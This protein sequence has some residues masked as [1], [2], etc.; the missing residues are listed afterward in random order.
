MTDRATPNHLLRQSREKVPSVQIA[1][2]CAS[3][4]EI[5]ELVNHYVYEQYGVVV[6]LDA[7]YIGKLERGCIRW[8]NQQYREALRAVLGAVS[9]AELGFS[10]HRDGAAESPGRM[11]L[12]REQFIRLAGMTVALP[13]MALFSPMESTPLP[14]RI[15]MTDV[16]QIRLAVETFCSW[17]NIYG[18]GWARRAATA[19]L[20]SAAQ[21]LHGDYSEVIR[22]ALFAA[23]GELASITGFMAFDSGAYVDA[24][25]CYQFGLQ[26]AEEVE[27][28]PLRAHLL[29]ELARQAAWCHQGDAALT[30]VDMAFVRSDHLTPTQLACLYTV[31]ARAYGKLGQVNNCLAAVG[32][33][34]DAFA[35]SA[36]DNVDPP[37]TTFYDE[38]QHHGDT[39]HAL[40]DIAL[41]GHRTEA[42]PRLAYSVTHH[43]AGYPRSISFSRTKLASLLMAT[44]DP[45]E[46]VAL[47]HRTL[48]NFDELRSQRLLAYLG[49]LRT[50]A[51]KH[52][53]IP[54]VVELQDRVTEALPL[55]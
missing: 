12:N 32:L 22:P 9:D 18:G 50:L 27:N 49:E 48:E 8:P 4:Q 5:A 35:K 38:A 24:K 26:C 47:G 43:H 7:N 45:N 37:W 36:P 33:A 30:Y 44:G 46:A 54:G 55:A 53:A 28:W 11:S 6:E 19:Q 39:A 3:R 29:S 2:E 14:T 42:A 25:N 1:G 41:L 52:R 13:W 10:S 23:V 31:K 17:D 21:L 51:N 20:Q 34:D 40:Y 16:S 15:T